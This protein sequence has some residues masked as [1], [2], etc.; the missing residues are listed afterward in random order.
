MEGGDEAMGGVC[1][2]YLSVCVDTRWVNSAGMRR[3]RCR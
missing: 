2:C 3:V 1:V